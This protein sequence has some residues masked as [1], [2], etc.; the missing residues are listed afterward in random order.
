M[1]QCD[2]NFQKNSLE[3]T[4]EDVELL[5]NSVV[6]IIELLKINIAES[7]NVEEIQKIKKEI[8]EYAGIYTKLLV[9]KERLNGFLLVDENNNE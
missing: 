7:N 6:N 1:T 9:F 5:K 8:K 4:P 3:L 2:S